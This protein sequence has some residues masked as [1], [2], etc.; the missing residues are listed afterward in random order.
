MFLACLVFDGDPTASCGALRPMAGFPLGD[1]MHAC[2]VTPHALEVLDGCP[3]S[4]AFGAFR[5]TGRPSTTGKCEA[6]LNALPQFITEIDGLDIHF[7]HVR[8]RS[9]SPSAPDQRNERFLRGV[10]RH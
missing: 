1:E 10:R 7:I 5:G 9:S 4:G 3:T 8:C 2:V 6:R